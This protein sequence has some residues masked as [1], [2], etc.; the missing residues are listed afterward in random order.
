MVRVT[1][2]LFIASLLVVVL[3]HGGFAQ[4]PDGT[5]RIYLARH[6]Q[7]Y[8]NLE[9]RIQGAM[10]IPLNATGRRQ[11]AELAERL[12]GVQ[13]N[14]VYSSQLSR[15]R[16]T[17]EIAHG[18]APLMPLAGLNERRLGKFEGQKLSRSTTGGSAPGATPAQDPLTREYDRRIADPD[19]ALDTGESLK[20]CAARIARTVADLR[21]KHRSGTI[22]IVGHSL[23]NQMVLKALLGLTFEQATK[24]QQANDDLFLIEFS[25]S[26]PPRTFK[27][28]DWAVGAR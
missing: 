20:D 13:L 25:G 22:L 27:L 21:A 14:A 17:A 7:T 23:A 9:G 19:D 12:K 16:E 26:E 5:L 3:P 2:R 1:R 4:Q 11:A 10:D 18:S 15:S 24:I 28:V 8:W 6:G